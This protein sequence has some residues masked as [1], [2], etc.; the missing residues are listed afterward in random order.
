M[1][2]KSIISKIK[3]VLP[4]SDLESLIK[5]EIPKIK[6][7]ATVKHK[8]IMT[9][10]HDNIITEEIG[11]TQMNDTYSAIDDKICVM[12]E[13]TDK[14]IEFLENIKEHYEEIDLDQTVVQ[15]Y[16]FKETL[17]YQRLSA[18][19]LALSI[20][21]DTLYEE[22][23]L[24]DDLDGMEE[25]GEH[26]DD[27]DEEDLEDSEDSEDDEEPEVYES[28]L[29]FRDK[30]FAATDIEIV[31]SVFKNG[32][33]MHVNYAVS[34]STGTFALRCLKDGSFEYGYIGMAPKMIKT[35]YT[36][37]SEN[38]KGFIGI[39]K[40]KCPNN[41]FFKWY[42]SE[43][44]YQKYVKQWAETAEDSEDDKEPEV[45]GSIPTFK[46]KLFAATS[47]ELDDERFEDGVDLCINFK[48]PLT[49]D[50]SCIALRCCFEDES[51]AYG[52]VAPAP[53]MINV[54]DS[55]TKADMDALISEMKVKRPNNPVLGWFTRSDGYD[56]YKIEWM[57]AKASAKHA[58][59]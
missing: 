53:F 51:F 48:Y 44:G 46:D 18:E 15:K 29:T 43:N 24:L 6:A 23:G 54:V 13:N 25:Y 2:Y 16:V 36:W 40:T 8:N 47:Y 52:Y 34:G 49:G 7:Y 32:I 21:V 19:V 55:W 4:N 3:G 12:V 41:P 59:K 5:K 9:A 39:M 56:K 26:D 20:Y 22:Y 10:I 33:D 14:M 42:T 58:E 57:R 37:S 1:S 30:L 11:Y 38:M 35:L 17:K 28:E 31:E 27:E 45:C 50:A